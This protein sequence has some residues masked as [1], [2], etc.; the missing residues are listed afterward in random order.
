M[1]PVERTLCTKLQTAHRTIAIVTNSQSILP[2]A[3]CTKIKPHNTNGI[4]HKFY[5]AQPPVCNTSCTFE[6]KVSSKV[7]TVHPSNSIV[8][9]SQTA[10][11]WTLA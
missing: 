4:S 5:C 10:S 2:V 11:L 6:L 9:K 7:Q 8:T 1:L 3:C